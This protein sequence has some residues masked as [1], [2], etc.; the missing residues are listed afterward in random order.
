VRTL[1]LGALSVALAL[2]FVACSGSKATKNK[3]LKV[4]AI[5]QTAIEEP[6]DGAIHTALLKAKDQ[7]GIV[8]E[9]AEKVSA[10]DY[11]KVLREYCER[12]FN[13][14]VG[15]AFVAGEDPVRK[16]AKDYPKV[17]FAFGSE[18]AEEAPNVSVFDN[19]IHEPAYL[20]GLIAGKMTKSGT[21]GVVAAMPIAEINRLTNAF[22]LGAQSARP[23]IKV[24]ITYIGSFFDPAKA[25]E[26]TI[27][28]I[29]A[30]ADLIYAERFGVFEAAKEKKV[31]AFGNMTDQ[32][33]LAP[34]TVI[35][36]CV[37]DMYPTMK[38]EIELAKSGKVEAI[39]LKDF[40]MMAK[41]GSS[42]AS[43]HDF[44]KTL[45]ADVVSAVKD[46]ESKI[47]D[48]SLAVPIVETELA[49]D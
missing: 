40:S 8:Y 33:S 48:G 36:S 15:D 37:W 39:N 20:C 21:V 23:S 7:D 18:K 34:E 5:F 24:K 22:K 9:Y 27:S 44:E 38:Y 31:L 3:Q 30:G 6:W 25:K 26:A 1:A 32:N 4:A 10:A 29:E 14:I 43:L 35:T 19:Y 49:S 42:L 17:Q 13:L 11:E 16:V 46:A 28:E 45:P 2:S 47:K 41:G 12:G